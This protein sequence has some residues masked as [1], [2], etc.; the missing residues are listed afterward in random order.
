MNFSRDFAMMV[1]ITCNAKGEQRRSGMILANGKYVMIRDA[2]M[3]SEYDDNQNQ[4]KMKIWAKTDERE[5]EV[6][7]EVMS[8]IPLRNRRRS[9][10]GET[11]MTR[12]TEGMTEFRC[13]GMVGYGLSEY[14]DQMIDGEPVGKSFA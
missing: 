9:P 10:D 11:M 7:G 2:R 4:T 5:Y 12:I 1:S 13:D 3:E 6:T 8:L 14:L